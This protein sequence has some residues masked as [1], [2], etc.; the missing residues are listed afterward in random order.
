MIGIRISKEATADLDDGY[1]FYERQDR[2]LGD[3]FISNISADIEGL[4]SPLAFIVR[5]IVTTI[6]CCVRSF[7]MPFTTLLRTVTRLYGQ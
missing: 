1:W 4:K 2:G 5:C 6:A 3:Y 7:R